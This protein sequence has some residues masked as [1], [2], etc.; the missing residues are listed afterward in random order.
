M[1]LEEVKDIL[2]HDFHLIKG[3][4]CPEQRKIKLVSN[5]FSMCPDSWRVVGITPAALD[6]FSKHGFARKSGMRVNRAHVS[7]RYKTYENMLEMQF[8]D[9][10]KLWDYYWERDHTIL[11]TSSENMAS[12]DLESIA[13]PIPQDHRMLFRMKGFAWKHGDEEVA[14]L[15]ELHK[16]RGSMH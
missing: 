12:T 6:V 1:S 13:I 5:L 10:D 2:F 3:M 8:S 16:N 4:K 11:S 7:P 9:K 15:R 14:F